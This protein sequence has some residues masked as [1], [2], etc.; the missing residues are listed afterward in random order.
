MFILGRGDNLRHRQ[1]PSDSQQ[2][3][4][5]TH[6][7]LRLFMLAIFAVTAA[8][9]PMATPAKAAT[10]G[11]VKKKHKRTHPASAQVR[12]PAATPYPRNYSEDPDRKAAGG[13]Y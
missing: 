11:T 2:E 1:S 8:A 3:T 6:L 10:D 12:A 13:G 9:V 4:H 7:A 5:M